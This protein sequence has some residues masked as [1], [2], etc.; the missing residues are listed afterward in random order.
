MLEC[1]RKQR[2]NDR[3]STS[4]EIPNASA[5]RLFVLLV[6]HGCNEHQRWRNCRFEAAEQ[7]SGDDEAGIRV[8]GGSDGDDGTPEQDHDTQIFGSRETLHAVAMGELKSE[9]CNIEDPSLYQ[10]VPLLDF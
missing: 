3:A 5:R 8:A 4:A 7:N 10:S 2:A 9:V 6:P 1:V